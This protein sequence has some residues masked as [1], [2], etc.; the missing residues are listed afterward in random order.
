MRVFSSSAAG[1]RTPQWIQ[2]TTLG[3]LVV[4]SEILQ[5]YSTERYVATRTFVHRA[6]LVDE[7]TVLI[8]LTSSASA[9]RRDTGLPS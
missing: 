5:G 6:R 7:H 1:C 9:L 8:P 3:N 2:A 4:V